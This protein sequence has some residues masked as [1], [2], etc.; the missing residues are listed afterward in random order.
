MCTGWILKATRN[1]EALRET[2]MLASAKKCAISVPSLRFVRFYP[3]G[4]EKKVF[5][6]VSLCALQLFDLAHDLRFQLWCRR[7][8]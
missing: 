5:L 7:S 4:V 3:F 1:E 6:K 2:E 8:W